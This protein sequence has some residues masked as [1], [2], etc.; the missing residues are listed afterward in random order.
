MIERNVVV[1]AKQAHDLFRLAL[2]QQAVVDENASQ[3]F[4]DRF[5]DQE[6]GDRGIDA[7]REAAQ[8]PALANLRAYRGDR[9]LP[10]GAHGPIGAQSGDLVD[11]IRKQF[12]AVRR[13]GDFEMKL[14]A[15]E[16]A[17]FV[18]DRRQRRVLRGGDAG[19]PGGKSVT[20][21]PWLI[22]TG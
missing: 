2:A 4:A 7:A 10:E 6:R 8:N 15:V 19:N 16:A 14:H 11:E 18:G 12:R 21:S 22:Q 3:L 5:M 20:A 9:F 1:V 17:R 13:V